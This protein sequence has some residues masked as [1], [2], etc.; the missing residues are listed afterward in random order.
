MK[1]KTLI[2]I[3]SSVITV[4]TISG[5]VFTRISS[6]GGNTSINPDTSQVAS[7]SSGAMG[8]GD[9]DNN[10]G[11]FTYIPPTLEDGNNNSEVM[12]PVVEEE[13]EIPFVPNREMD[14]DPTSIT[15][16]VNKEHSIPKDYKPEN[17]VVPNIFFNLTYF[18]ERTLMRP[19]A[20]VALEKLFYA[21]N[22]DGFNLSGVSGYRSYERQYKIFTN[23]I[24]VRGKEHTL[25]YSAVPGT[26]EHQTGLAI[27][28]SSQALD[29]KLSTSFANKP[30]GIW[31][32]GNA[33]RF[34]YIVRYPKGKA[35]ITGYAYEPWHIRYVGKGLATY[36]Y[37]NE[38][39]LDEYYNYK[40][41][42]N[43]NFETLYA[44]LI[45]YVSPDVTIIPIEGDGVIV[46]ENGE[47]I[48]GELEDG[49]IPDDEISEDPTI[50][51]PANDSDIPPEDGEVTEAPLPEEEEPGAPEGEED[52]DA[53]EDE[54]TDPDDQDPTGDGS[55][56]GSDGLP[57]PA[58]TPAVEEIPPTG[59]PTP[60]MAPI[61]DSTIIN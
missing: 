57:T 43:F 28:I 33:H 48:E 2:I 46:G 30:E 12:I 14:L 17:L 41:S 10:S 23:N 58:I 18:D 55:T 6:A 54:T 47:I 3:I 19:E 29:F 49:E 13:I 16:F 38:L 60:T 44:D 40:P 50:E 8:N 11:N 51:D 34:G 35:S 37:E 25:K 7:A 26:S 42:K 36:L 1:K 5:V 24:V 9:S 32:A 59:T 15:V 52:P 31:L 61:D 39:T 20:A 27:D 45:N 22:V 56:T 4:T 53:P 21:A